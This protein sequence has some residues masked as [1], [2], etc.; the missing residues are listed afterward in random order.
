MK[1]FQGALDSEYYELQVKGDVSLSGNW[2][3]VS[4]DDTIS[5]YFIDSHPKLRVTAN[6]PED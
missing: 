3:L 4:S 1:P 5:V 6:I 2:L